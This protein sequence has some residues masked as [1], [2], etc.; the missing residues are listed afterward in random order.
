M[1]YAINLTNFYEPE[2]E[3][4]LIQDAI[5]ESA[6]SKFRVDRW[7]SSKGHCYVFIDIGLRSNIKPFAQSPS[8]V[9]KALKLKKIN[10]V[11]NGTE[12]YFT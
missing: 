2:G 7:F 1:D 3:K 9:T 12:Q 6:K 10:I 4:P 11:K 5:V 8:Q